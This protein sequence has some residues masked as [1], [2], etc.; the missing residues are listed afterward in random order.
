MCTRLSLL[1]LC[2][3]HV[4][5]VANSK[6]EQTELN[7]KYVLQNNRNSKNKVDSI[8]KFKITQNLT[9]TYQSLDKSIECH[10]VARNL[11]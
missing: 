2:H 7:V 8:V 1:S 4:V 3:F 5:E 10:R 6:L 11:K 9:I